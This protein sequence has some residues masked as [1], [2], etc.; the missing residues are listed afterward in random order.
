[1]TKVYRFKSASDA[2]VVMM[3]PAAV[4]LLGLIGKAPADQGIIEAAA[5]P[6]ALRALGRATAPAATQDR[7]TPRPPADDGDDDAAPADEAVALHQ[8]AWPL[9]EMMKRAAAEG[10]DIV[11]GV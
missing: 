6:E 4:E 9:L 1:M 3:E 10:H 2:D 11:W 8:R 7:S 5:L